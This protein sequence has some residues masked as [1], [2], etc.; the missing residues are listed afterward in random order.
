MVTCVLEVTVHAKIGKPVHVCHK[1]Y[2]SL[3][4]LAL[5]LIPVDSDKL[6][7]TLNMIE[8]DK[9]LWSPYGLRSL[10]ASDPKYKT[11]EVYWR[12]P[13]WININFLTLQS[14]HNVWQKKSS[15]KL[16]STNIIFRTICTHLAHTRS[17]RKR[18]IK[19]CVTTSSRPYIR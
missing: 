18:S 11:G 2:A 7:A 4:P 16:L 17:K 1:G 10:S 12:G 14:L 8:N 15:Q 19:T 13:I 5:G 3:L 6:G 9:E